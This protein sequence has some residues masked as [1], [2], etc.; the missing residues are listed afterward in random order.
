[1][2]KEKNADTAE[3]VS[4]RVKNKEL[5]SVSGGSVTIFFGTARHSFYAITKKTADFCIFFGTEINFCR[6]YLHIFYNMV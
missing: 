6:F 1:M 5:Y 2:D 4:E 3:A